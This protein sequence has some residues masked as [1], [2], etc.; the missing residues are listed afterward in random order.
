MN[1]ISTLNEDN[2]EIGSLPLKPI[3][4]SEWPWSSYNITVTLNYGK[5]KQWDC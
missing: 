3:W 4:N 2:K 1:S 5:P